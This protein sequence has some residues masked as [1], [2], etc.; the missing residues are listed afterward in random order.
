MSLIKKIGVGVLI[1]LST[2]LLAYLL[3]SDP[4]AMISGKKLS[5]E[6]AS[7]AVNWE[8]CNQHATVA[9]EVR[10]EDPYSV[11]TWCLVYQ[12]QMYIPASNPTEKKWV[13]LVL[14]NPNVRIK[15][16]DAIY[17]A[18][19]KK[20]DSLSRDTVISLVT[21]KYPEYAADVIQESDSNPSQAW[22]FHISSR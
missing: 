2:L 1:A 3:R 5:G 14:Q 6:V 10:P 16:G 15:M 7:G 21:T 17:L 20:T 8:I 18:R 11:T 12:G 9:I 19:A 13:D 4:I 22:I